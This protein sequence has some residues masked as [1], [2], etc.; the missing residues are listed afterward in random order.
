MGFV[1][2]VFEYFRRAEYDIRAALN[3]EDAITTFK[4]QKPGV[5]ILDFNLPMLTGEKFLPILQSIN[6][7]VKVIMV[8]GCAEDEIGDKFK[9]LH[10]F[11]FFENGNFSLEALKQKIDEALA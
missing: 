4:Q 3:L 7:S 8:S 5:V 9:G 6:P 10:Y 1:E 2:V 11:A